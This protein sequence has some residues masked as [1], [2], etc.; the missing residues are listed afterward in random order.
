MADKLATFI[1][2]LDGQKHGSDLLITKE[3]DT[4]TVGNGKLENTIYFKNTISPASITLSKN[5]T[6]SKLIVKSSSTTEVITMTLNIND[7]VLAPYTIVIPFI[8]YFV[9]NFGS[10]FFGYITSI[11]FATVST[12]YVE[13]DVR[14][15]VWQRKDYGTKFKRANK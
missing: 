8:E 1:I 3:I 7:G 6:L 12:A 13:L 14:A 4:L 2:S 5:G 11:S 10:T 15:Y 9:H